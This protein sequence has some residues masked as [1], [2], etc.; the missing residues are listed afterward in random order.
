M[1]GEAHLAPCEQ[2]MHEKH[3]TQVTQRNLGLHPAVCV[4][5]LIHSYA[6]LHPHLAGLGW[7]GLGWAGA[8]LGLSW[9]LGQAVDY[10]GKRSVHV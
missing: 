10:E 8:E 2:V 3:L 9:G 6:A 4:F 1:V 7:A 5:P